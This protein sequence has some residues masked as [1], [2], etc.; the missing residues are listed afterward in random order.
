[1]ALQYF[2][3]AKDASKEL[4][5]KIESSIMIAYVHSKSDDWEKVINEV[6]E[7]TPFVEKLDVETTSDLYL[8]LTFGYHFIEN[9]DKAEEHWHLLLKTNFEFVEI[10]EKQKTR[11]Y[12]RANTDLLKFW[13]TYFSKKKQRSITDSL[14]SLKISNLNK[15]SEFNNL[16]TVFNKWVEARGINTEDPTKDSGYIKISTAAELAE[17]SM[18]DFKDTVEKIIISEGYQIDHEFNTNDGYDAAVIKNKVKYLLVARKW[19]G[20]I[21]ELQISQ[22]ITDIEKRNYKKGIIICCG[23]FSSSGKTLAR[24]GSI[25]LIGSAQINKYIAQIKPSE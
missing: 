9:T 23:K 10:Y 19:S 8:T 13:N 17:S 18:S 6:K 7:W 11:D 4:I 2:T 15:M 24:K 16:L 5:T 21:G 25:K 3:S 22:L 14:A 20:T 12:K 1:M